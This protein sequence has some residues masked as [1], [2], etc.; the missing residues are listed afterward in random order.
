VEIVDGRF[1]L[2]L[3]GGLLHCPHDALYPNK[4]SAMSSIRIV[5]RLGSAA[6]TM[7]V[8]SLLLLFVPGLVRAETVLL[9]D[10]SNAWVTQ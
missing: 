2:Q 4:E 9:D 3:T 7:A 10:C 1:E 5:D 6:L 8:L